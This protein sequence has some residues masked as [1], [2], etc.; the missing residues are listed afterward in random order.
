MYATKFPNASAISAR[1]STTFKKAVQSEFR[2]EATGKRD[3]NVFLRREQPLEHSVEIVFCID[4]SGSMQGD[5][6]N[7][8]R[9]ALVVFMESLRE[10]KIPHAVIAFNDHVRVLKPMEHGTDDIENE[11]LLALLNPNGS[12]D[13]FAALQAASQMME[14]STAEQPFIFYLTDGEGNQ[15]QK[16]AVR[17]LEEDNPKLK[18]LGIGVGEGCNG[19]QQTYQHRLMVPQVSELAR[20]LGEKLIEMVKGHE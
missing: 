3:P 15:R 6:I 2:F 10:L 12:T 1:V 8:A 13:D 19:V 20:K 11:A 14:K 17:Q 18:V 16:E 9:E 4:I 5:K 7:A